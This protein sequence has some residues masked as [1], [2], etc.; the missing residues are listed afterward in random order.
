MTDEWKA[1]PFC[2][3]EA[4]TSYGRNSDGSPWEYVECLRCSALAMPDK[5]DNRLVELDNAR[6][7]TEVERLKADY[8]AEVDQYNAGYEAGEKGGLDPFDDQPHYDPDY[9]VWRGGYRDASYDRLTAELA[10][11]REQTRW[12]PISEKRYPIEHD[13]WSM[14]TV[15]GEKCWAWLPPLP[16]PPE[17]G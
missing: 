14:R 16:Q 9:D 2:G 12:I 17:A 3:G 10:A 5:W 8:A 6:L 4:S 1:C 15:N 11:L 7:T 13:N